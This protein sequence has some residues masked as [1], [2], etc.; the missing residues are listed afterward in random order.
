VSAVAQSE[1]PEGD[2]GIRE[3]NR[4]GLLG[5]WQEFA[6]LAEATEGLKARLPRSG[7]SNSWHSRRCLDDG[8][9]CFGAF[10]QAEGRPRDEK[11]WKD[12]SRVESASCRA[13]LAVDGFEEKIG[14]SS[15]SDRSII[16]W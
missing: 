5:I 11:S 14:S 15:S 8:S 7:S 13:Q 2:A 10:P 12:F 4:G 6:S 16:R 1:T 3:G 9:A